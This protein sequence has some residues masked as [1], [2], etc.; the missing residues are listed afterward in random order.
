MDHWRQELEA[1]Q[2]EEEI[3]QA[4]EAASRGEAQSEQMRE[5]FADKE[6]LQGEMKRPWHHD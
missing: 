4:R 5:Q 2:A 6:Q 3:R 1:F